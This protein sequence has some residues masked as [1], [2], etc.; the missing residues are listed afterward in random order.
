MNIFDK[1]KS[2]C[3]PFRII[4]GILAILIGYLLSD[5][6]LAWSWWYLGVVPL[7]VGLTNFCPL[8]FLT[9]KCDIGSKR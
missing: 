1:I 4:V 6:T 9:N 8:C 3:Q 5:E 2:F 7:F